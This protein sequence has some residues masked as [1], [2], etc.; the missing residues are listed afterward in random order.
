MA[1]TRPVYARFRDRVALADPIALWQLWRDARRYSAEV[2]PG[3]VLM[4]A[5]N[6]VCLYNPDNCSKS[7]LDW[8]E[9]NPV[10]RFLMEGASHWPNLDQSD[11]LART[12]RQALG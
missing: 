10:P 5:A 12:I 1:E 4:A 9:D 11:L 3:Y 8:L 6:A 2:V 7:T